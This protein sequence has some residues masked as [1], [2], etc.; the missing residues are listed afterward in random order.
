MENTWLRAQPLVAVRGDK[1][2]IGQ[3]R[4][5]AAHAVNLVTLPRAKR[6]FRIQ[7]PNALEQSLPAQDFVK[8]RDATREAIGRIEE[9]RIGVRHLNIA[10]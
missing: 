10:A 3:M 6:F 2:I 5:G 8:T 1:S 4:V 9:R 7:A